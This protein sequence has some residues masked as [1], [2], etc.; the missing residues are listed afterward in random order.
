MRILSQPAALSASCCE[1]WFWSLVETLPYPILAMACGGDA[2]DFDLPGSDL[3]GG[4]ASF[5]CGGEGAPVAGEHPPEGRHR[6]LL[7][8]GVGDTIGGRITT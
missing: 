5:T 7:E 6:A 3:V 8:L 1:S 2:T 4:L